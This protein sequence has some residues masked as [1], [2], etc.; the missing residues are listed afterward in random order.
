MA[1][2]SWGRL[3]RIVCVREGSYNILV[4]SGTTSTTASDDDDDDDDSSYSPLG[5]YFIS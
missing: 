5:T 4:R 2:L 1:G 3:T